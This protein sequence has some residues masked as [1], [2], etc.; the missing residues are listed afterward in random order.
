MSG[1]IG[2]TVPDN[3]TANEFYKDA[4]GTSA[5]EIKGVQEERKIDGFMPDA[6]LVSNGELDDRQ[7]KIEQQAEA[8]QAESKVLKEQ[9]IEDRK[10]YGGE[11]VYRDVGDGYKGKL[12]R[13]GGGE[14]NGAGVLRH[15]NGNLTSY[16]I[17]ERCPEWRGK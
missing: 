16:P 2:A 15:G 9:F 12:V 17:G 1:G 10:K 6:P 14:M 4:L 7:E 11:E 8:R 5:E 3:P 13:R